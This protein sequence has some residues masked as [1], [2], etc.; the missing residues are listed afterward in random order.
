M[1]ICYA[2]MGSRGGKYVALEPPA[3]RLRASRR[4]V[5]TDWVM[6]LTIFGKKVDLKGPF[7]RE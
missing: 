4:D 3:E 2:A 1:K 6:A 7:G 5:Q